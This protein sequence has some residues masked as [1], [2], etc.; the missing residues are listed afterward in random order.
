MPE[1]LTRHPEVT[2]Q[3]LQSAG[4]QC[5]TGAPQDILKS[6]PAERFCKL[7]GGE[8]CVYGL[9]EAARMTQIQPADWRAVLGTPSA[10]PPVPAAASP[11]LVGGGGLVAGLLAGIVLTLLLR[12]R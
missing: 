4:A 10:P 5:A 11:L 8:L 3:V 6:C 1:Q 2:Q 7:P 9:P 12:R